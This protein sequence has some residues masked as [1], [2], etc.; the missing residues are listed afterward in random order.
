M[1]SAVKL[2]ELVDAL[3]LPNEWGAWVDR[4]T[5]RVVTLSPE[6]QVM[7]DDADTESEVAWLD[8]Q[9]RMVARAIAAADPRYLAVPDRFDFHEYR[10]LEQ[11]V[12]GIEH[13]G[14]ADQLWRA[15]KG[16]GAF[17]HF[18]QTAHRLGLLDHWYG[19]RQHAMEEFLANWA[20]VQGVPLDRPTLK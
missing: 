7:D 14:V 4:E 16:K 15:I 19:Y 5:G 6:E 8:D 11:F 13:A 17:R 3:D 1:P 10:H 12:A 18:K 2:S 20:K 9:D